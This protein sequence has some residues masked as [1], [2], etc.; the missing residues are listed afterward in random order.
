[1]LQ[2]VDLWSGKDVVRN[3]SKKKADMVCSKRKHKCHLGKKVEEGEGLWL[4]KRL[5]FALSYLPFH[6]SNIRSEF[7]ET[8]PGAHDVV[9]PAVVVA[10]H[11]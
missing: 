9:Q 4:A 8:K 6:S 7:I 11:S 3:A 1:M 5:L 2:S 10:A